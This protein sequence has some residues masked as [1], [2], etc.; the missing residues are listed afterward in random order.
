MDDTRSLRTLITASEYIAFGCSHTWGV[1]VEPNETWSYHLGA[2]NHG[3]GGCSADYIVRTAPAT[4]NQYQFKIAYVLWPDW[5]RFE[6]QQDNRY[7]QSLP[8][9]TNRIYFMERHTDSWCLDNFQKK[10]TQ[11]KN[12]CVGNNIKL[13]DM[14]LYDLIPYM[15]HADRWPSSKLG[16]HYAPSWH[17][18]VADIFKNAEINNIKHPLNNE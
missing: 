10:V 13:I 14:T 15:D 1:G 12:F 4:L 6:Y 5:T 11:F 3:I 7:F 18:Q 17:K 2:V 16:H 8:T 9:D